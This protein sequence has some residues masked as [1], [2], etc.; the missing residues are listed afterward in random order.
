MRDPQWICEIPL[1]SAKVWP[2]LLQSLAEHPATGSTLGF[3]AFP[4]A[5]VVVGLEL[6]V[7]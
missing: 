2:S 6:L 5:V 7:G 3:V 4:A 1:N